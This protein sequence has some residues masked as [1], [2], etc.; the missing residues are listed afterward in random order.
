[1]KSA[2]DLQFLILE[3]FNGKK[4]NILFILVPSLLRRHGSP[5]ILVPPLLR[6]H[7]AF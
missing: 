6:R 3:V 5:F 4:D 7:G 2:G 1:M